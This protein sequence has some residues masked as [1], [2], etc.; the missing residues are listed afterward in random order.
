MYNE[1]RLYNGSEKMRKIVLFIFLI[2]IFGAILI[3][4]A[5]ESKKDPEY[6]RDISEKL[7]KCLF[8]N[9]CTKPAM[10]Q[11]KFEEINNDIEQRII[12]YGKYKYFMAERYVVNDEYASV[13]FRYKQEKLKGVI[14]INVDYDEEPWYQI[15]DLEFLGGKKNIPEDASGF[16]TSSQKVMFTFPEKT[17]KDM[18]GLKIVKN[19]KR[20]RDNKKQGVVLLKW[21]CKNNKKYCIYYSEVK[22]KGYRKANEKFIDTCGYTVENLIPGKKYYFVLT[23]ITDNVVP[24]ESPFSEEISGKA[25]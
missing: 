1:L 18:Y 16:A 15:L 23:E 17:K 9:Q 7:V 8:F 2:I 12:Q 13:Y 24:I 20:N 25:Y 4:A 22:G 14:K 10:E 19:N 5:N 21:K 6:L 3:S 11:I